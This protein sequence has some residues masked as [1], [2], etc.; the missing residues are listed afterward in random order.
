MKPLFLGCVLAAV[1]ACASLPRQSDALIRDP[2]DLPSRAL[3]K[4]VEFVEQKKDFCGPASLTM[5]LNWAG[6]SVAVDDVGNQTF[7][8]GRSG[9]LQADLV[10]AARRNGAM[11][12]PV[13]GMTAL[14]TE[15]AAG[16]PVL[17]L[18]NLAFSWYPKWHYAVALGYELDKKKLVLHSG[19]TA[20]KKIDLKRFEDSW[21][22]ASYWG[23]VVLPPGKLS[24]T[25]AELDHSAAAAGL[26]QAGKRREAEN[27][28]ES[29]LRKWPSSLGALIGLG[30]T[31][32]AAGDYKNSVRFLKEATSRHKDSA[33]AW[34]NLAIAQ[35]AARLK[36]EA[37]VSAKRALE[38]AKD[39]ETAVSY[40]E[41]L[42]P[43]LS[44]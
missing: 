34:H 29:I 5:T 26:E 13:E 44:P 14:L 19:E 9:T 35:G 2:G 7:T 25:G 22:S 3:V 16:H 11:A 41:S 24:A 42:S 4:D 6:N 15:I 37:R 33:A 31:R 27:S 1:S 32:Y 43:W 30:N 17:V 23:L 20:F 38:L 21:A 28:Y 10:S 40:K 36:S 12:V 39:S 8:P 18:Q